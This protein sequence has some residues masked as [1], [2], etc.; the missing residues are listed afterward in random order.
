MFPEYPKIDT[1]FKRDERTKVIP[2]LFTRPTFPLIGTWV[3]TEKINGMNIRLCFTPD[4]E[5]SVLGRTD[6]ATIPPQL[7]KHCNWLCSQMQPEVERAME[8]FDLSAMVFHGEGYGAQIHGGGG[9]RSDQAFILF[10]ISVGSV[11]TFLSEPVVSDYARK[12][13][14]PMVP[15]LGEMPTDQVVGLT[16]E[17]FSSVISGSDVQAE[18]VVCRTAEPMYDNRGERVSFKLKTRDF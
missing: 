17:G 15:L 8:K 2:G 13:G 1:L 4:W 5:P 11:M 7:L 10:D 18:G 3:V 9:Y 14:I 16:R 6:D 12:L